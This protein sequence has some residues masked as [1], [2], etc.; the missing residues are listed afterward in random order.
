[1][2]SFRKTCFE[3]SFASK[4]CF[5]FRHPARFQ[6]STESA[7]L[8]IGKSAG[9]IPRIGGYAWGLSWLSL[10]QL[11]L[12]VEAERLVGGQLVLLMDGRAP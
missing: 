2:P 11:E 9:I 7:G 3:A 6:P 1:M 10:E 5:H 4:T 8:P 12:N